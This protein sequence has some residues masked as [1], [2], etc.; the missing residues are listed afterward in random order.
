M[1]ILWLGSVQMTEGGGKH[2]DVFIPGLFLTDTEQCDGGLIE[3]GC[4]TG[5]NLIYFIKCTAF[6]N[7]SHCFL[8]PG[9][10]APPGFF[11]SSFLEVRFFGK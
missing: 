10:P 1:E 2:R 7:F 4:R 6:F 5:L 11:V 9:L 8:E 3:R